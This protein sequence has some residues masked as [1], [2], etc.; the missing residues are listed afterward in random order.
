MNMNNFQGGLFKI[1]ALHSNKVFDV[2]G[3]KKL[4]DCVQLQQWWALSGGV[5][6]QRENQLFVVFPVDDIG[7]YFVIASWCS[8]KVLDI[9][10]QSVDEGAAVVQASF[11]GQD[12]QLFELEAFSNEANTYCIRAKH[13]G[14]LITVAG[15]Q[16]HTDGAKIVQS[17]TFPSSNYGFRFEKIGEIPDM[18]LVKSILAQEPVPS[19]S[20]FPTLINPQKPQNTR[21]WKMVGKPFLV[22]YFMVE[23]NNP[24][25]QL[26][27]SPYYVL[28]R[29]VCYTLNEEYFTYNNT[30]SEQ[31]Y[32]VIVRAGFTTEEAQS[33]S[34]TTGI[35]V[36]GTYA[37]KVGAKVGAEADFKVGKVTG[38]VSKQTSISLTA[39]ASLSLGYSNSTSLSRH[40]ET[41][42]RRLVKCDQYTSLAVWS[43]TSKFTL[44]R[45][46]KSKLKTWELLEGGIFIDDIKIPT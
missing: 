18:D 4:E 31:E 12:N 1:V 16:E 33:F 29:E 35:E 43:Q 22:P 21:E 5:N 11:L 45:L 44:T 3:D 28:T 20:E 41:E 39:S 17:Q 24:H 26:K 13:S 23:D 19:S 32:E 25:W 2:P 7:K 8:G 40:N 36:S 27:K 9:K 38:E 30:A 37:L 42:I 14:K 46:D 6:D 15:G 10:G 34:R